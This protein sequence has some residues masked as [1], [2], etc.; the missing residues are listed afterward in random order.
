MSNYVS[1]P[2]RYR[3]Q[4]LDDVVGQRH[5][6]KTLRNAIRLDRIG[7]VYLF[8]GPAG[9]GKT[10]F[11]RIWSKEMNCMADTPPCNECRTC[12]EIGEGRSLDVIELNAADK[13][14]IE[15]IR[16]SLSQLRYKPT[17]KHKILILDE[18]HMLTTEAF[19]ALLKDLEE[20][21]E[22]VIF[23]LCT[24]NPEKIPKTIISRCQTFQ[25]NS[26][27]Q[28]DVAERLEYI[29][30]NEG[31]VYEPEALDLIAE[32][33]KGG[34]RDAISALERVSTM[35]SDDISVDM[36]VEALG[37]IRHETIDSI[38]EAVL[39]KDT[40]TCFTLLNQIVADGKSLDT[41]FSMLMDRFRGII[42]QT[43]I[44]K[45][46]YRLTKLDCF[47]I[48]KA[49]L[50]CDKNMRYSC[51]KFFVLVSLFD[52]L[53]NINDSDVDTRLARLEEALKS[54]HFSG[55]TGLDSVM[56]SSIRANLDKG[57]ENGSTAATTT[58]E[59]VGS[60]TSIMRAKVIK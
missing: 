9:T 7:H 13:R 28:K 27:E 58:D 26:I 29:C 4:T 39:S 38:V 54:G 48:S 43:L 49:L 24:T 47:R 21:R 10:S 19:N 45:G 15:D 36:T 53:A 8:V 25:F 44:G 56:V 1:L 11:A 46:E 42:N 6:V 57:A 55:S 2:L 18:V 14:K 59:L 20:P 16:D 60:L 50:E 32:Y 41:L 22:Y 35:N 23:I 51:D 52:V 3:P 17:S 31:F 12:R 34:M 33:S 40:E 5:I 37:L 30:D